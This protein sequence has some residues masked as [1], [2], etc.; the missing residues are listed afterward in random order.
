[1]SWPKHKNPTQPGRKANAPYNFVPLP[2]VVVTAESLPEQDQYGSQRHTGFLKCTLTTETPLYTRCMMNS[3]FYRD[4][5]DKLFYELGDEQ[6]QE[7]GRFFNLGNLEQPVIPGSSLR[8]M[9]RALVEILAYGKVQPVTAERLIYRSVGDQTSFGDRYRERLM[10][11]DSKNQFT[12]LVQAGYMR[13]KGS[14][15]YIQPA[16]SIAAIGPTTFARIHEDQTRGLTLKNWYSCRNARKIWVKVDPYG[17]KPVRHVEIKYADVVD[18]SDKPTPGFIEAV[19]VRSG[20]IDKKKFDMVIFPP[21]TAADPI[22]IPREMVLTYREQISLE[23]EKLLGPNGVLRDWQPVFY[24]LEEGQLVFFSHTK[25][26]RLPYLK[27]PNFFVP[28]E[29]RSNQQVDLAEAIFGYTGLQVEPKSYAGRVFFGDAKLNQGQKDVFLTESPLIPQVLSGPKPTSFQH[30]LVQ[31]NPDLQQVGLT[32]DHKPVMRFLPAHYASSQEETAIRG[33]KLY[34]HKAHPVSSATIEET[35]Q[36]KLTRS[37]KQY[38]RIQPVKEGV[39]FTFNVY[40]ENLSDVELGAL[41]WALELPEGYRHKL[42]MGKPL[43][44][45][46]V[47]I[48]LELY[49]SERTSRYKHLFSEDNQNWQTGFPLDPNTG[50]PQPSETNPL[51]NA[52]ERYVMTQLKAV[53]VTKGSKLASLPRIQALLCLL[54]WEHRPRQSET[55]YMPLAAFRD[56]PV[57][58]TPQDI[59]GEIPVNPDY[60]PHAEVK[61]KVIGEWVKGQVDVQLESGEVGYLKTSRKKVEQIGTDWVTLVVI[62]YKRGIY[63]LELP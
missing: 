43:G 55:E 10:H 52:F 21:D 42:G 32:K 50:Q 57:L 6:K 49:L 37:P 14:A 45:G 41:L 19:H 40:F 7:R 58:P 1:M 8:G 63:Y 16:Q 35:D 56:R 51:K 54:S 62:E 34:W 46:S 5:G 53:G 23:Q 31:P 11:E 38:T 36:A 3:D 20:H 25:M 61:A 22:Q 39:L 48:T 13:K 27:S 30:Y 60:P 47:K 59:L 4:F 44:L 15:W 28:P 12:P 9:T 24:L 18:A 26:L 29:L 17:Y 2:E 33:H